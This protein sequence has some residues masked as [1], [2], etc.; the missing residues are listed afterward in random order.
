MFK[1]G[2]SLTN[3]RNILSIFIALLI[4]AIIFVIWQFNFLYIFDVKVRDLYFKYNFKLQLSDN[5]I[6]VE[7]DDDTLTWR[8]SRDWEVTLEWLWRFPFDRMYYWK[9]IDNITNDWA[10][11]I[12]LDI[13]FWEKSNDDSDD[14][15]ATSIENSKRVVLWWW[16]LSD[17]S[18][19]LPYY[20]FNEHIL[21]TWYY[22]PNVDKTDNIYENERILYSIRPFAK[23]RWSDTLYSH[24]TIALLKW[25]YS[26]IYNDPEI[27]NLSPVSYKDKFVL[28][29]KI[30]I[31][32]SRSYKNELLINYT[33]TDRFNKISFLDAYEG[34]FQPWYFKDKII[35]IW[36]TARWIKDTFTTPFW[37]TF[38]VYTHANVINTLIMKNGIRYFNINMEWFL[39]FLLIVV[40]VYFNISKSSYVLILSNFSIISLLVIWFIYITTITNVLLNFPVE[41][42]LWIVLSLVISNILKYLIENKSK[43]K[44]NKA[45]SEYVSVDVANEILSG[46]WKINLDWE[47]K[48]I[49]IFFS[50][51]EWFTS[52]SEKFSAE[53][54]VAFLR[55]YLSDM[56]DIIMDEKWFINK[57]EWDA[58]MA[59]WW[60]FW[61]DW[62]ETYRVCVAALHQ[63]KVL[64]DLNLEWKKR[65]FSR[66][67]ARIWIHYW[68]AIIWNIWSEWRKMEFTALWDSVN[69]ASRLEWVNK[70]YWTYICAS[71]D[72]YE[73]EKENFEFRYLDQ[74]RVKWKENSIKIYEL[75]SWKWDLTDKQEGVLFNFKV[76]INLYKEKKFEE[77]LPLFT[78]LAKNWD[79]P[80]ITYKE[81]C[82][83][84]IKNPPEEYWDGIWT[85]TSK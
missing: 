78:R 10:A 62:A 22:L 30:E 18:L 42:V 24:F 85:M 74:I 23:F 83:A 3:H 63:Q 50:D 7:I 26:Y 39:I 59:L 17:W 80:S 20:K 1:K 72:I 27:L 58:I 70:F 81:R 64:N 25:Y 68:N 2:F 12:W 47:D 44:L 29:D 66:I 34:N 77:A 69:L 48:S 41:L 55:E 4:F 40:S 31:L 82:E 5:I 71:E 11:V 76:A 73:K 46:E 37:D 13:I 33:K 52:I 19:G 56:S 28:W 43:A 79:G 60:V 84:Y 21:T 38:W 8:K 9:A 75:L 16:S 51:I 32:K 61:S 36:A 53:Q 65:G 35:I 67:K 49:A 14:I 45:L 54:L 15:L 57:Y 6:V